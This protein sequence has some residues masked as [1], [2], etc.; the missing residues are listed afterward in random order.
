MAPTWRRASTS[1]CGPG[2]LAAPR[3]TT[4]TAWPIERVQASCRLQRRR[5]PPGRAGGEVAGGAVPR[6]MARGV[7]GGG[8][9]GHAL[10]MAGEQVERLGGGGAPPPVSARTL[11]D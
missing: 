8:G 6:L 1:T 2:D 10:E 5:L 11:P 7:G 3:R 4:P 9:A